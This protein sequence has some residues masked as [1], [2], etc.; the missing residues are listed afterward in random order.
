MTPASSPYQGYQIF[1]RDD[2]DECEADIDLPETSSDSKSEEPYHAPGVSSLGDSSTTGSTAQS[3]PVENAASTGSTS[4]GISSASISAGD[5]V[6]SKKGCASWWAEAVGASWA[7][8]WYVEPL[9]LL[10]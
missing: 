5:N 4:N 7:Y 2:E 1:E 9:Y 10:V 8:D 3:S 6:K